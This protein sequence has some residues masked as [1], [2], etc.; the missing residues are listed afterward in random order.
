MTDFF[1]MSHISCLLFV[2]LSGTGHLFEVRIF[3][4]LHFLGLRLRRVMKFGLHIGGGN[5]R[6][7][8]LG[9]GYSC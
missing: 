8:S 4:G 7:V 3:G 1:H 6:A 9:R 2:I 5:F